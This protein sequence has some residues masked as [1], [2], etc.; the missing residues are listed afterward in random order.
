MR[1]LDQV[2]EVNVPIP[3]LTQERS[4]LLRE[5][6]SNFHTRYQ[7]L[8]AIT[9]KSRR[10]PG[11]TARHR[12]WTAAQGRLASARRPQWRFSPGLEGPAARLFGACGRCQCMHDKLP[13]GT[14]SRASAPRSAFTTIVVEAGDTAG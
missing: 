9:S 11:D 6:A 10:S 7:D 5:W 12:A 2:Y 8:Y 4:A 13:P 14:R 1:Y 3:D